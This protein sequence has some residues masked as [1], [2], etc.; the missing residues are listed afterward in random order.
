MSRTLKLFW[1]DTETT[2]LYDNQHE[3][4]ELACLIEIE[5][6]IVEET[7]WYPKP[8]K[9]DN[10]SEQSLKINRT[11]V[12]ELQSRELSQK[13]FLLDLTSMI[14]RHVDRKNKYD[15]LTPAGHNVGFDVGFLKS[16]FRKY[17]KLEFYESLFDYH[18]LDTSFLGISTHYLNKN[19]KN[20]H[21]GLCPTSE[22]FGLDV[23]RSEL[24]GAM[25]DTKLSRNLFRKSLGLDVE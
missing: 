20:T 14:L 6:K 11:T 2:G 3:I 12:E 15:F 23:N 19:L 13:Q 10:I 16:L 5:G 4:I 17:N 21:Y 22:S 9:F 1:M 24:H 7:K 25:Y 8:D 18:V